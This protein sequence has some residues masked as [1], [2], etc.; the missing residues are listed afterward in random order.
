[1]KQI[2][3]S[4]LK[5]MQEDISSIKEILLKAQPSIHLL[6]LPVHFRVVFFLFGLSGKKFD[7]HSLTQVYTNDIQIS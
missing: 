7:Q 3:E 1:M 4:R 5:E 6:F 2:S